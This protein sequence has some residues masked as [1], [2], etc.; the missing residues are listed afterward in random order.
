MNILKLLILLTFGADA[1]FIESM[2]KHKVLV[3]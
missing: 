2:K 1:V 3:C